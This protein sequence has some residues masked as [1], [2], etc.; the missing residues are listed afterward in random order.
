MRVR[1]AWRVQ[2]LIRAQLYRTTRVTI[3]GRNEPWRFWFR[4]EY[5]SGDAQGSARDADPHLASVARQQGL[6]STQAPSPCRAIV[7]SSRP[8][9]CVLP[10]SSC[11]CR[12]HGRRILA[13]S[14]VARRRARNPPTLVRSCARGALP[15]FVLRDRGFSL[16]ECV[17]Q[18]SDGE[19]RETPDSTS[20]V[21]VVAQAM[22]GAPMHG[23]E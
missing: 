18:V 19:E 3:L 11:A 23:R 14:N 17:E 16:S 21:E 4:F 10:R 5:S 9:R 15:C 12:C 20:Q 1:A 13:G 7:P 8:A 22:F 6:T 2:Q